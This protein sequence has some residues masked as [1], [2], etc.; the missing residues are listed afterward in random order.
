M[1]DPISLHE[2]DRNFVTLTRFHQTRIADNKDNIVFYPSRTNWNHE[3][4]GQGLSGKI[5]SPCKT[6]LYL[7]L[8]PYYMQVK[9]P[10]SKLFDQ[11]RWSIY[12]QQ[13]NRIERTNKIHLKRDMHDFWL[14]R[15]GNYISNIDSKFQDHTINKFF[16]MATFNFLN[17]P[18]P[19]SLTAY[20]TPWSGYSW[21]FSIKMTA[22]DVLYLPPRPRSLSF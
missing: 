17:H 4:G 20:F 3:N 19:P 6:Q 21:F 8:L 12:Y 13:S 22:K 10:H 18:H 7:R 1:A 14:I 16:N 9:W 15:G 2:R 5:L 11:M